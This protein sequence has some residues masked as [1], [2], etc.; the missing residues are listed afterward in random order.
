VQLKISLESSELSGTA[1][2]ANSLIT[3]KRIVNTNVLI[4]DGGIV[5]LGGLIRDTATR[6][7][8]RVPY[9]GRIPVLGEL[10]KTRSRKLDKSNLMVFIRPKI[11]RDG[12]AAAIATDAKY[13]FI[14][15]IQKEAGSQPGEILP[16]IPFNKDPMLPELPPRTSAPTV[17]PPE[18]KVPPDG[19]PEEKPAKSQP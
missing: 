14:R 8:Q 13:N 18:S 4:E 3:N 6:G 16:L 19:K 17:L 1:G 15:Q 2:D 12:V 7:E 10:F 11:L 9:L 5:V